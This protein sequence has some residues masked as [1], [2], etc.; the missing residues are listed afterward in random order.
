MELDRVILERL[1]AKGKGKTFRYTDGGTH[2]PKMKFGETNGQLKSGSY[3]DETVM[4][5]MDIHVF[6]KMKFHGCRI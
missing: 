2:A 5:G 3:G 1:E 4:D 6:M